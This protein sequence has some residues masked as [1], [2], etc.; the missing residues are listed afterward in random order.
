MTGR[1]L[2]PLDKIPILVL[3]LRLVSASGGSR[4][5]LVSRLQ[6]PKLDALYSDLANRELRQRYES[7]GLRALRET[8]HFDVAFDEL[9][10]IAELEAALRALIA[11]IRPQDTWV[12]AFEEMTR[13]S[14]WFRS[15]IQARYE[16]RDR[17]RVLDE[18]VA[19]LA[20]QGA[21]RFWLARRGALVWMRDTS[22]ALLVLVWQWRDT[23]SANDD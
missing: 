20:G 5:E 15:A 9:E 19:D 2:G 8:G 18:L 21:R 4:I 12:F 14:S 16:H 3:P 22:E 13:D 17:D 6:H 23:G 1:E 7:P 11:R 10:H